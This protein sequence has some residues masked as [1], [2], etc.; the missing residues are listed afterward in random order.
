MTKTVLI[1]G[2][3]RGIGA[4]I[5]ET[6]AKAGY[7]IGINYNSSQE[8]AEQLAN[9]LAEQYGV[10][11]TVHKCNVANPKDVEEMVQDFVKSHGNISTLVC[12]AGVAHMG[13][14]SDMTEG[15]WDKVLGTNLSGTF[16]ACRQ[17]IP[18][19]VR[20][21]EGSI[22]TVSS[23]W[24]QEGASCEAAY[25]ATKAGIIGLTKALAKELGPSNIRVNCVAPGMIATEMN[26][27]LSEEDVQAIADETPLCRIGQPEEVAKAVLF[28]ASQEASFVTGQVLGVNGG[29]V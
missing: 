18:Y 12:N 15:E 21:Q 2:A 17:V 24:G 29:M 22:V 27:C 26:N 1:T 3:S 11:V 6:F 9:K 13:L 5:A 23:M 7:A 14:L 16:Y 19:M 28:L 4:A 10:K 8:R 20:Q 25:S